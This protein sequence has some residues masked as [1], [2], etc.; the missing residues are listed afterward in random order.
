LGGDTSNIT[1]ATR[2][3]GP[4]TNRSIE[5]KTHSAPKFRIRGSRISVAAAAPTKSTKYSLVISLGIVR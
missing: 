3:E 5:I 2:S 4:I 1:V